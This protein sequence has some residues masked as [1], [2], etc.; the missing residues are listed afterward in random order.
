[1]QSYNFN[2]HADLPYKF[3]IFFYHST[4]LFNN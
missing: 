1:M 3:Y 2:I 4:I